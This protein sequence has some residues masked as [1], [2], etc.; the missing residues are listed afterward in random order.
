MLTQLEIEQ[1][2]DITLSVYGVKLSEAEARDQGER[3]IRVMELMAQTLEP[4]DLIYKVSV[5]KK[6]PKV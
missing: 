3:L 5:E 6:K 1:F 4:K 2:K